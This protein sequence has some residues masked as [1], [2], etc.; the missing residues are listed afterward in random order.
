MDDR[1]GHDDELA[2]GITARLDE[3]LAQR[4]VLDERILRLRSALTA[5]NT[6]IAIRTRPRA[7]E[8]IREEVLAVLLAADRPMNTLALVEHERLSGHSRAKIGAAVT[9]LHR[10]GKIA[11]R[12]RNRGGY[13]WGPV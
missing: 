11:A 3:A 5:L 6:P 4:A 12:D 8:E 9:W 1:N 7:S 13:L 2:A 10:T